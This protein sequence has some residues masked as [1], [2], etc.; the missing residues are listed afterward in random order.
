MMHS[1]VWF[2]QASKVKIPL[3][4]FQRELPV[5]EWARSVEELYVTSVQVSFLISLAALLAFVAVSIYF[6][7][8]CPI[9]ENET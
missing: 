1:S 6:R 7:K 5:S 3:E 2:E 9:P 4:Y 8:S